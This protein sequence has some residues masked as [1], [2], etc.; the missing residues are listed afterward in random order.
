LVF[1]EKYND[2]VFLYNKYKQLGITMD[3]DY[4][5]YNIIM[6]MVDKSCLEVTK[7]C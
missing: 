6:K 4:D 2:V 3:K 7:S 5:Y 1:C